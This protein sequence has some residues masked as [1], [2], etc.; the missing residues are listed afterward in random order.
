MNNLKKI[1]LSTLF[2]TATVTN[3][4]TS[5]T[6]QSDYLNQSNYP[7]NSYPN[8]PNSPS[9]GYNSQQ[10]QNSFS[11]V[12]QWYCQIN[13]QIQNG[14]TYA[15]SMLMIYPNRQFEQ[16]SQ[17]I[18]NSQDGRSIQIASQGRGSW[19]SNGSSIV[20]TGQANTTANGRTQQSQVNLQFTPT[21]QNTMVSQENAQG[22]SSSTVCQRV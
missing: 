16:Q 3:I 18:F 2:A 9:G 20:F 7:N 13:G 15:E 19:D 1:F 10:S 4:A 5:A 6:A 8:Q 22:A 12:G 11:P 17:G 14:A 21:N